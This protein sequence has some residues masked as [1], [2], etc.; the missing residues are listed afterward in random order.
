[1]ANDKDTTIGEM[2]DA[3]QD[4]L[5]QIDPQLTLTHKK[6]FGGAGFWVN[7]KIF[8]AW[9]GNTLALKLSDE[10]REALLELDGAQ[11]SMMNAYIEIPPNFLQDSRLM[12]WVEKAVVFSTKSK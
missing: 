12:P 5:I 8:A 3:L 7:G 4:T 1:M 2:A 9:F 11:Q 6:M 10:D